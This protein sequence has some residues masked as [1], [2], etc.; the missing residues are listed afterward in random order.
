MSH[1]GPRDRL[2]NRFLKEGLDHFEPHNVLELLLF[3]SIPR[4]DTNDVAHNLI[5]R[6]GSFSATLDAPYDEL[7]KVPGVGANTATLIKMITS[8]CRWYMVDRTSDIRSINSVEKA[9]EFLKPKFIGRT[10]EII[11]FVS[12][13]AKSRILNCSIVSEGAVNEVNL[14]IR[15]VVELVMRYKACAGILA[16]NHPNG[17]AIPS[18]DDVETTYQL[19]RALKY[20]NVHLIDHIIVADDDFVSMRESRRYASIFDDS[21][22]VSE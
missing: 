11:Y 20:V 6:F 16:H 21:P 15:K 1:N 5:D 10:E 17:L 12:L 4:R 19:M 22:V 9:G 14:N 7:L 18:E 3:Y 2:R 8:I 13:D